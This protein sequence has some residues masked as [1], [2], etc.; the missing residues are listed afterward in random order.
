MESYGYEIK[1]GKH[2]AIR[3]KNQQRFIRT[4]TI[5]NN[6]TEERIKERILYKDK[7]VGNI[8]EINNSE[9]AKSSKGY[10]HWATKYNLKTKDSTFIAIRDKGFNQMQ[11]LDRGISRISIAMNELYQKRKHYEGCHKNLND[12]IYM[13]MN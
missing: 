1:K 6:Y 12:K 8:I 10:E 3:S 4:Q 2:I 9:K 11:E 5:G 13:M 7:E